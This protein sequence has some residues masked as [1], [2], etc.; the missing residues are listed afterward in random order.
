MK[1][2]IV[3]GR[4]GSGKTVALRALEDQGFYCVDNI[5]IKLIPA[6]LDQIDSHYPGLAIGIDARN[7]THTSEEF[8]SLIK[9][10][11]QSKFQLDVVFIDAND[12][13]L[14]KRFSETRRRHPLTTE[15]LS[16]SEAIQLEKERLEP[17]TRYAQLVID[18]TSKSP[19]E[20]CE[21]I[22]ERVLGTKSSRLSLLFESFGFKNGAPND[23]DFVFDARCL[24]NP[25]WEEKLRPY[26][27]K[28]EPIIHYL[29]SQPTA[30]EFYWQLK[31]FLQT[32]IPRFEED[33][34]NYL[35]IAI[36]CTGGQHRSVYV[37][38]KLAKNFA[39]LYPDTQIRHRELRES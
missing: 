28:D 33:N 15:G 19:H 9:Q 3:S 18:T 8:D 17:V 39:S 6:L 32:W 34:R 23:A 37:A 36:G 2:I 5:P 24:P 25:Y 30:Q 10:I 22:V 38:E 20:L 14:L 31:V 16:L 7:V 12:T 27:G 29:E 26:T 21:V 1:R 4:S 35:T 13:T 11:R